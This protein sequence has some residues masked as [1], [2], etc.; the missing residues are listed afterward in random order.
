MSEEF[1]EEQVRE[2][3]RNICA[4][5]NEWV[6]NPGDVSHKALD[7]L[8]LNT[9]APVATEEERAAAGESRLLLANLAEGLDMYLS[10]YRNLFGIEAGGEK[11]FT[12]PRLAAA[13][14][15]VAQFGDG[16]DS[17][18]KRSKQFKIRWGD[19]GFG[20]ATWAETPSE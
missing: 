15:S 18:L 17:A 12:D 7:I 11:F 8:L 3:A 6:S 10:I 13:R 5:I 4:H 20:G 9:Y 16:D 19:S 1:T 2:A 14:E